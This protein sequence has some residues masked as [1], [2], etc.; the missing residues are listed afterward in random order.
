MNTIRRRL[1]LTALAVAFAVSPSFSAEA[2]P[3]GYIGV[4]D[5]TATISAVGTL[6]GKVDP[7]MSGDSLKAM[8]GMMLGDASLSGF[9]KGAGAALFM[10]DEKLFLFME[11]N[12]A[13][14][15]MYTEIFKKKKIPVEIV[16]GMLMAVAKGNGTGDLELGKGCADAA[17]KYLSEAGSAKLN[18]HFD[19]E[20]A[21]P[22]INKTLTSFMEK[23]DTLSLAGPMQLP[24]AP[25][26][27]G[28]SFLN[29]MLKQFKT[30]DLNLS[31]KDENLEFEV[32]TQFK[33]D[34]EM[35]KVVKAYD[36]GEL[37]P[38]MLK[39]LP[40]KDGVYMRLVT[41]NNPAKQE[42]LIRELAKACKTAQLG[43]P[44]MFTK[45]EDLARRSGAYVGSC[46][47]MSQSLPTNMDLLPIGEM[48]LIQD[49]KDPDN[50]RKVC[51]DGVASV[52]EFFKVLEQVSSMTIT[53]K[54]E[55]NAGKVGG[56]EFDRLTFEIAAPMLPK[57]VEFS[58][59][60]AITADNQMLMAGG[61]GD[62]SKLVDLSKTP[63]NAPPINC[64]KLDEGYRPVMQ[65]E[66]NW[67][68]LMKM[69]MKQSEQTMNSGQMKN[70]SEHLK[71]MQTMLAS[72]GFSGKV[73]GSV[74]V[75]DFNSQ[76]KLDIPLKPFLDMAK[77]ARDEAMKQQAA[78]KA[79]S[80]ASATTS[81][82]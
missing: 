48:Y 50:Y 31:I 24:M 32:A 80:E 43:N 42:M 13:K 51:E 60:Y 47:A 25:M 18:V 26:V 22:K 58:M 79:A 81:T 2:K 41:L 40:Y 73:T 76:L 27:A 35:G 53:L 38:Q 10:V 11:I 44:S 12:K 30:V 54:F 66:Y 59:K 36:S 29:S 52:N 19:M 15:P 65:L 5:V 7:G 20:Q 23:K 46:T 56:M 62:L 14:A 28:A 57:K 64:P 74:G 39:R 49:V 55:K 17:K 75:K 6:A 63:G 16:D 45:V 37:K 70:S 61:E 72:P 9:D 69:A 78:M 68:E 1:A 21:Y 71:L 3:Y 4:S 82:K 8:A 33:A 34:S 77:A 67:G